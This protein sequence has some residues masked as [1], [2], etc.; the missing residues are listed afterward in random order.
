M[1][2][3]MACDMTR[4][5]TLQYTHYHDP[6]YPWL[7]DVLLGYPEWHS[8][9]HDVPNIADLSTVRSVFAWYMGELDYLVGEL[10]AMPDGEGRLLD[11]MLVL[12]T[13]ELGD[14]ATHATTPLPV[15]LAGQCGGKLATGRHLGLQGARMGELYLTFL[16]MFGADDTVFGNPAHCSGPLTL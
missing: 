3:A 8:L 12:A 11:N 4:V 7:G 10:A 14:G 2:M 9:V 6:N 5:G 1:V 13:S 16:G 15:V